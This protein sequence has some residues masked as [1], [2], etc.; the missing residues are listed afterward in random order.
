MAHILGLESQSALRVL[1]TAVALTAHSDAKPAGSQG[2]EQPEQGEQQPLN[3][4]ELYHVKAIA[5]LS[6]GRTYP[7]Q[8]TDCSAKNHQ[9]CKCSGALSSCHRPRAPTWRIVGRQPLSLPASFASAAALN[10][11]F[12]LLPTIRFVP[13]FLTGLKLPQTLAKS[14]LTI[15]VFKCIS[16]PGTL[17]RVHF[18]RMTE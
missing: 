7:K 17:Q 5:L 9:H 18:R 15:F 2:Q 1:Q 10:A 13:C 12:E 3:C 6:D 4:C 14:N 16:Q 11:A 8:R